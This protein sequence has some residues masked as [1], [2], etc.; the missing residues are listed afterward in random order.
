MSNQ[1]KYLGDYEEF[2]KI[3][4]VCTQQIVVTKK[5]NESLSFLTAPDKEDYKV[6]VPTNLKYNHLDINLYKRQEGKV[7][8]KNSDPVDSNILEIPEDLLEYEKRYLVD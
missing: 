6:L 4:L 8:W 5:E 3:F 2:K 1:E 7:R